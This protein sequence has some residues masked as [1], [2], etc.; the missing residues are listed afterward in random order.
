[1]INDRQALILSG[2]T[3]VGIFVFG[4]IGILDNF[5]VMTILTVM[6]LSIIINLFYLY[7]KQQIKKTTNN[8]NRS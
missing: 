8:K 2:L 5:I 3:G 6:F 1:M 7:H 4:I